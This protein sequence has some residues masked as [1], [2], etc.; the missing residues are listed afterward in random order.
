VPGF[1]EALVPRDA[2][3]SYLA[4]AA[5]HAYLALVKSL[6]QPIPEIAQETDLKGGEALDIVHETAGGLFPG[7][8][9]E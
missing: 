5:F 8:R 3:L 2:P 9:Q 7:L 1:E 6:G 4:K